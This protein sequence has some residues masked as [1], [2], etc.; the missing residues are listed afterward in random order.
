[1]K[2]NTMKNTAFEKWIK[3]IEEFLG[4]ELTI[5]EYMSYL[6]MYTDILLEEGK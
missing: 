1:M 6:N 3:E 2:E 5:Q 4:Y